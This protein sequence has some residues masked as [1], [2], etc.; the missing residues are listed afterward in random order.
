MPNSS[1]AWSV[2]ICMRTAP[3]VELSAPNDDVPDRVR[4]TRPPGTMT[5]YVSP[6]TKPYLA[7]ESTS[8]V[9]SPTWGG[10]P[11]TRVNGL[12]CCVVDPVER[13]LRRAS[14]GDGL[15]V[16]PDRADG[17]VGRFDAGD[18]VGDTVHSGD[19]GHRV[20]GERRGVTEVGDVAD[21]EIDA[22]GDVFGH[23]G[24]AAAQAVAEHECR[25]DEADGE[26]HAEGG[27]GE[28]YLVR[29]EVLEG[30][31]KHGRAPIRVMCRW[32]SC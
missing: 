9:N 18:G 2:F 31:S 23:F 16:G 24:E 8:I 27:E 21:L 29:Q 1:L 11:S 22:G 10:A 14:G 15:A 26:H 4:S 32:F 12:S 7:A 30:E 19:D 17:V 3:S 6:M 20:G 5:S 28:T 25:D 13:Q